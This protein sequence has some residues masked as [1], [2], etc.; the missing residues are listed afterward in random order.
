MVEGVDIAGASA[1]GVA[2]QTRL[3]ATPDV[4]CTAWRLVVISILA[5]AV[6]ALVIA[7]VVAAVRI[8]NEALL[9]EEVFAPSFSLLGV[10]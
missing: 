9:L 10:I 8:V 4:I 6:L 1:L 7:I 2:D 5:V 3:P